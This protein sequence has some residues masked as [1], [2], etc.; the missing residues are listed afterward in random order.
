MPPHLPSF[1]APRHPCVPCISLPSL[2]LSPMGPAPMC[3]HSSAWAAPKVPWLCS[4]RWPHLMEMG[5]F[6]SGPGLTYAHADGWFF[7]ACSEI[8]ALEDQIA[9]HLQQPHSR[10][11]HL[12]RVPLLALGGDGAR[13]LG[14]N[15]RSENRRWRRLR[16]GIYP[17]LRASDENGVSM[18]VDCVFGVVTV[19]DCVEILSQLDHGRI[20]KGIA[21]SMKSERRLSP[22]E[23]PLSRYHQ[24]RVADL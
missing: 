16:G 13:K 6:R 24:Y 21:R 23:H 11:P 15:R 1:H 20:A 2:L 3:S 8:A 9:A 22:R 7:V 10:A 14:N 4:R 5:E 12:V 18:V 19:S 17:S